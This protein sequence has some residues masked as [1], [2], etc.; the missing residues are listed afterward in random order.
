MPRAPVETDGGQVRGRHQEPRGEAEPLRGA[1]AREEKQ[2]RSEVGNKQAEYGLR[3]KHRRVAQLRE[4]RACNH[5]LGAAMVGVEKALRPERAEQVLEQK[6][7][8]DKDATPSGD[9]PS[10]QEK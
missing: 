5:A 6:K 7:R 2:N 3:E 1:F 10:T 8:V 4:R 9:A